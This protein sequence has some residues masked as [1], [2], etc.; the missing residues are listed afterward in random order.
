MIPVVTLPVHMN[1][2]PGVYF[3]YLKILTA[4]FKEIRQ[5]FMLSTLYGGE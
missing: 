4:I 2:R 3:F 1:E 5:F